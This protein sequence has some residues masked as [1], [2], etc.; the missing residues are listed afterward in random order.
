M[1]IKK[2]LTWRDFDCTMDPG[3]YERNFCKPEDCATC[4]WGRKETERRSE[5]IKTHGLTLCADG[6]RRL[7]MSEKK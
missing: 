2:G 4:G 5:Y 3:A 7:V 1:A 6:L